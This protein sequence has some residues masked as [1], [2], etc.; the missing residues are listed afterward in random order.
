[1][2]SDDGFHR[3]EDHDYE[4]HDYDP[5]K[6][7]VGGLKQKITSGARLGQII[8]HRFME[9]YR[10]GPRQRA[11]YVYIPPYAARLGLILSVYASFISVTWFHLYR[12]YGCSPLRLSLFLICAM[13]FMS[14]WNCG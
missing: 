1:M 12:L 3:Q 2:D 5:R 14:G 10:T 11:M 8:D 7:F 4:D 6:L 13:H 9:E